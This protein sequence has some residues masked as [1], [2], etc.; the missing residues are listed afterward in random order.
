MAG[1]TSS[2]KSSTSEKISVKTGETKAVS[3]KKKL[4]KQKNTVVR[5]IEEEIKQSKPFASQQHKAIVNLLFSYG[6]VTEQLR[7]MIHPFGM[8]IQQYNVLRILRG[9]GAPIS[10]SD[11]RDRMLD[12]MSD[13][14]RLVDRLEK[15]GW[16]SRHV[17]PHDK[18]LVD[19][20]LT[21]KGGKKLLEIDELEKGLPSIGQSLSNKQAEALSDLLDQLR[22]SSI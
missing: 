12:R 15:K 19:I 22:T 5:T 17:C 13:T 6:W 3:K 18:R 4:E 9:A 10:T 7:E 14:S 11:I 1:R 8:T 16:V 21:D 2:R 20:V